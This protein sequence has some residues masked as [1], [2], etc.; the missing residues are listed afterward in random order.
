MEP[1]LTELKESLAAVL[2][3]QLE[4]LAPNDKERWPLALKITILDPRLPRAGAE[5]GRAIREVA[6]LKRET[7]AWW[8]TRSVPWKRLT[9]TARCGWSKR[10]RRS[11][12]RSSWRASWRSAPTTSPSCSTFRRAPSKDLKEGSEA[13]ECVK[14]I[15][16]RLSELGKL[17]ALVRRGRGQLAAAC[18]RVFV[19]QL[20]GDDDPFKTV[21]D[22]LGDIVAESVSFDKH[23]TVG[24]LSER[25]AA[26]KGAAR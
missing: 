1:W 18:G 26:S 9:R 2:A 25:L 13:R 23:R 14:S 15:Q 3:Q 6:E 21:S 17:E 4:A 22:T 7:D 5:L 24:A 12:F 19:A 8:S 20:Q 16:K 10:A 11:T